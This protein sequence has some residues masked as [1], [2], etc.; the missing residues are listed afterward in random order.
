MSV[1]NYPAGDR[2]P[3]KPT[4][5]GNLR[6]R[7]FRFLQHFVTCLEVARQR[8]QLLTLNNRTLKDIGISRVDALREAE[9]DFWDIPDELTPR[10]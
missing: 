2:S 3:L 5:A 4:I 10:G 1:A 9:R 6:R 8:R 7:L